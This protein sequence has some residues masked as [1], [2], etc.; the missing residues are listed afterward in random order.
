MEP[1][2]EE[3]TL[4]ENKDATAD[5]WWDIFIPRGNF[6]ITPIL[7][8]INILLFLGMLLLDGFGNLFNPETGVLIKWGGNVKSLTVGAHEWWRIITCVFEHIGIIHLA[9]NMYALLMIGGYLEP[10]LGRIRFTAA[11]LATGIFSSLV[12]LWWHDNTISAGASGAIFGMFGL[13][14]AL[15]TTNMVE[16]SFRDAM[17]KN[18]GIFI[19]F[20]LL[21]G[22]QSGVDNAAHIGGLVSGFLIGYIYYGLTL[23]T[24]E[25]QRRSNIISL[26]VFA[27]AVVTTILVVPKMKDPYGTFQ[28]NMKMVDQLEQD[29]MNDYRNNENSTD[30]KRIAQF[31]KGSELYNT[32]V[33][34]IQETKKLS[35][36]KAQYPLLDSLEQF[37]KYRSMEFQLLGKNVEENIL[38]TGNELQ[39]VQER[40]KSLSDF[41]NKSSNSK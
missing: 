14:F 12:S 4:N 23:K 19:G 3:T 7:L 28:A 9:F 41:F 6:F 34:K 22:M 26:V 13:F 18:I 33:Q 32:C 27:A 30:E 20:N 15:L 29:A 21:F 5:H 39:Q 16:K 10:L 2:Q 36:D 25:A 24:E 17:L 35:L 37:Y 40:I 11:Y 38:T 31:K 8:V 1:L